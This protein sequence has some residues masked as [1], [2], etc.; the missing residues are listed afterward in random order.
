MVKAVEA[1]SEAALESGIPTAVQTQLGQVLRRCLS[2]QAE[3]AVAYIDGVPVV[4][5]LESDRLICVWPE[6]PA[7][8]GI[9]A[10]ILVDSIPLG[11]PRR[12][13]LRVGRQKHPGGSYMIRTWTLGE[14]GALVLETRTPI[15]QDQD[16]EYGGQKLLEKAVARLGWHLVD[17]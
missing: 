17:A 8:A 1:W 12:I 4:V 15:Y 2:D 10:V 14:A 7:I 5:A 9:D 3:T 6:D 13:G 16:G 11:L